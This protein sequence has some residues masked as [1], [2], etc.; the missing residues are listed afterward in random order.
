[1]KREFAR[2][3]K[4]Y[5]CI[6]LV[7]GIGQLTNA[8]DGKPSPSD[9]QDHIAELQAEAIAAGKADFGHWGTDPDD[10]IQWGS[11]SNRLIPVYTFGTANAGDGINLSSY[12]GANSPYRNEDTVRRMYGY[13]PEGTVNPEADWMDQTNIM[14]MQRAAVK[15]GR[16][17]IFLVVFDGM[18]WNTTQA[19]AIHN[20]DAVL[21]S[22]GRGL[23]T[24]F[25]NYKAAGTSQFGWMVT[26]PHN[27]GTDTDVD[28]QS[29]S[30]PG[31][32]LR[33]GYSARSGGNTPWQ[34]APDI[35][36]LIGKPSDGHPRHAYTDSAA[37]AT[38]MT[39]GIKTYNGA[40]NI[41]PTGQ[42]VETIVHELQR[43]GYRVGI[44][45]SV[46]ISH[47]TPACAYAHNVSRSDY[48][49]I[50]RDML[51]LPSIFH[52]DNPLPGL[53]V[54]IGGGFGKRADDGDSQGKNYEP[55]NVYFAAS[56]LKQA[57]IDQG[58]KYVT[59]V[60]Q[61]GSNGGLMLR[62]AARRAAQGKHRLLGFYGVGKYNGHLPF[63]TADGDYKPVPGRKK[64]AEEYSEADVTENPTLKLMTNAA[65]TVLS[66]DD[67]AKGFWLMV[68]A[69]DVDWANHDDNLDNSIGAVN[70]G[71]QAVRAITR[72]VEKNSNWD[73]S[74]LI[75]TADHGHDFHLKKPEALVSARVA[76]AE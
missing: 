16:K 7:I 20:K 54:V 65:I 59:A 4:S 73:E 33:G 9:K 72:W 31:G 55:G 58:G 19:T 47:A 63:Q 61:Q 42:P 25:Q 34:T 36:Y 64:E 29:V 17:Y 70:S 38:S 1:M 6:G 24:H 53:D 15:A 44:V 56:D 68:E 62:R 67:E 8:E 23:G 21:Y 30:N 69:G 11:H 40:I 12:V 48:Q 52:P 66:A 2:C 27:D 14:D 39:A 45:S 35:G 76:V 37:S 22:E 51:G 26:S 28:D 13:V 57:N 75:V 5:L 3:V 71:D 74:L 60:R 46:P 10:Y 43:D 41:D 32:N 49:D 18:D 50:S